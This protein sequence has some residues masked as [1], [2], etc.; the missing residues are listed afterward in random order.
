M[1]RRASLTVE[2]LEERQLMATGLAAALPHPAF[3]VRMYR[4]SPIEDIRP[5]VLDFHVRIEGTLQ[6]SKAWGFYIRKGNEIYELTRFNDPSLRNL[7]KQLLGKQVVVEGING[8]VACSPPTGMTYQLIT[9]SSLKEQ[10]KVVGKVK[11]EGTLSTGVKA[12]GGETTGIVITN[13]QGRWELDL[14]N[15]PSLRALATQLQGKQVVVEG[16]LTIRQGIEIPERSIIK[17]SRLSL[18]QGELPVLGRAD[19]DGSSDIKAPMQ[20]ILRSEK[21]LAAVLQKLF[22]NRFLANGKPIPVGQMKAELLK[23]LKVPSIDWTNQML[24]VVSDG[25][26]PC[27]GYGVRIDGLVVQNGTLTIHWT[28]IQP[29]PWA[30]YAAMI[31]HPVHVV[32]VPRFNGPVN[33]VRQ[34]AVNR[35]RC[36]DMPLQPPRPPTLL[37]TGARTESSSAVAPQ[38]A[39]V[40]NNPMVTAALPSTAAVADTVASAVANSQPASAA[41]LD[42]AFVREYSL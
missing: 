28:E 19:L 16:I 4:I 35:P 9:V 39:A 31:T 27:A 32:L 15:N 8:T 34:E 41:S 36:P 12:I 20:R 1:S 26:K 23:K 14:G 18:V 33:F 5:M 10:N 29:D 17:V 22:A 21:E 24:M 40:S 25:C 3:P 38:A 37:F 7:A 42:Q 11:I 13:A 6:S 30:R 2:S